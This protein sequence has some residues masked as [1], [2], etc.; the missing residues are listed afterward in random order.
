MRADGVVVTAPTFDDGLNLPQYVED[1]TV[2]QLV[3]QAR[4]KTFNKAV[5]PQA[6]W[7]D[8]G[9]FWLPR[10]RFNPARLR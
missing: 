6:A 4:M 5:L 8:V 2:E 1:F 9:K 10:P 7:R 3:T